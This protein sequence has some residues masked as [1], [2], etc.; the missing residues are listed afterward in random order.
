MTPSDRL[1][2]MLVECYLSY[3]SNIVELPSNP[4]TDALKKLNPIPTREE[5]CNKLARTYHAAVSKLGATPYAEAQK[6]ACKCCCPLE[7]SK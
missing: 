4:L 2:N 6:E 1:D 7:K 5:T 3:G